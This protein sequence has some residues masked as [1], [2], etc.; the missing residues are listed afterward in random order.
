[1]A[2]ASCGGVPSNP[3]KVAFKGQCKGQKQS[4]E[5]RAPNLG[6][7]GLC[8]GLWRKD[9]AFNCPGQLRG[10]GSGFNHHQV[11]SELLWMG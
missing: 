1:M 5:D 3:S 2:P 7:D 8:L 10:L 11:K 6:S 4:S 9:L